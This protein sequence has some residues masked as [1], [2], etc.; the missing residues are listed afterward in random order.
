MGRYMRP[1][2]AGVEEFY[3]FYE[4]DGFFAG[5]G[6]GTGNSPE[7][8]VGAL[9]DDG[10]GVLQGE[11]VRVLPDGMGMLLGDGP[12][13]LPDGGCGGGKGPGRQENDAEENMPGKGLVHGR[14]YPVKRSL[15]V[16]VI[17]FFTILTAVQQALKIPGPVRP[18]GSLHN[19]PTRTID[20]DQRIR[21]LIRERDDHDPLLKTLTVIKTML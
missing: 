9:Q 4:T 15:S 2:S 14:L 11:G 16:N 8:G 6:C 3:L 18:A 13:M 5:R 10:G 21:R 20:D 7:D 17:N 19:L 12:P 1:V